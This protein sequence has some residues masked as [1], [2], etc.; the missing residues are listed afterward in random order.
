MA[1]VIALT[2]WCLWWII[3][4]DLQTKH[5]EMVR[6][7]RRELDRPVDDQPDFGDL[8]TWTDYPQSNVRPFYGSERHLRSVD[9]L[10]RSEASRFDPDAADWSGDAS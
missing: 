3:R 2:V 1:L 7:I 4:D 6:L 8:D 10:A 5:A 9:A